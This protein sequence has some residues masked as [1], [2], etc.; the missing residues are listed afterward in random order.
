[1]PRSFTVRSVEAPS[2]TAPRRC[3]MVSESHTQM[4]AL[5]WHIKSSTAFHGLSWPF[6][7]F[8]GIYVYI[9]ICN[10]NVINIYIYGLNSFLCIYIICINVSLYVFKNI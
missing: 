6:M 8:H 1:M 3:P 9:Y 5:P 2:T 4:L 7:A 10:L